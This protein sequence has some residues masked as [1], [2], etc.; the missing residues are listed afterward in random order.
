MQNRDVAE[1]L[2]RAAR[3]L[4]LRGEN[5]Y[6]IRAYKKAA[7]A[8]AALDEDIRN[9]AAEDRLQQVAGIGPALAAKIKEIIATGKLALLERLETS[10]IPAEINKNILLAAALTFS[11]ELV[12]NLERLPGIQQVQVA[13]AVRRCQETVTGLELVVAVSDIKQAKEALSGYP[14]LHQLTWKNTVGHA[15]HSFGVEIALYLT[16]EENFTPLLWQITGSEEHVKKVM[17]KIKRKTGYDLNSPESLA[18]LQI[19]KEEDI[20]ELA[21]LAP[22]I[23]ELREDWGEIEA[24]QSGKLPQVIEAADYKGDLHVHTNWSD[25]TASIEQMVATAAELGYE[26]LAITDHSRSLKIARGLSLERLAK[27]KKYIE[28]LQDKYNLRIL[29]GIEADILDD[30]SVD[31]PDE[32]LAE[33]DVV[34]ASVH[35]GFRQSQAKLTERICRAMQNPYVQVIGHATGRLLGRRDPYD[36]DLE[37]VLRVAA[38]TGTALEINSSPDRLDINDQVARLAKEAGIAVTINTDA[39]SQLELANIVLGLSVARRGWLEKKEVLN[40]YPRQ[41]ILAVLQQK[42]RR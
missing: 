27:Q 39:H 34:I 29:T 2:D 40:T 6:R 35:S 8:V 21:D 38:A 20:Y 3:V 37:E 32:I 18:K 26:Y 13:G 31:A 22:I 11:S 12:P 14:Q 10:Q 5:R 25:G 9:V 16:S 33:L 28:S 41:E 42:K 30:G 36:I 4:A 15:V 23:P 19:A 1:M 24:A 7:H 17:A